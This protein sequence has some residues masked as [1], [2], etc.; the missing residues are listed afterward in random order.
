MQKL[1]LIGLAILLSLSLVTGIVLAKSQVISDTTFFAC[2]NADGT[3][4]LSTITQDGDAF[5]CTDEQKKVEWSVT[6][7]QGPQGDPGPTGPAGPKG[8]TGDTGPA[9]PTGPQGPKGDTGDT[10]PAGPQGPQGPAGP[11]GVPGISGYGIVNT[12]FT[13]HSPG[14]IVEAFCPSGKV[15]LGG[16]VDLGNTGSHVAISLSR[17]DGTGKGW[18]G[19]Y[20]TIDGTHTTIRVWAIC[21]VVA[22]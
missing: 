3:L 5:A 19:A 1:L 20:S 12:G 2:E 7:P 22:A 10:G 9:G 18:K 14:V 16:G 13:T 21:A 4:Q 15:V 11:Q 8:D 6:G 17:P